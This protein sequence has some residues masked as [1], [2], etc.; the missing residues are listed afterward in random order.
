MHLAA[1]HTQLEVCEC[2]V[3]LSTGQESLGQLVKLDL[4]RVD[5]FAAA[6]YAFKRPNP[7]PKTFGYHEIF[8][9]LVIVASILHFTA[10]AGLVLDA[11]P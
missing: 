11:Q 10:V 3:P 1:C 6:V 9:A 2:W 5:W 7:A 8:H 4:D